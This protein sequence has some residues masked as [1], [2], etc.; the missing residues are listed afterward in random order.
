MQDLI[1]MRKI[2]ALT[3]DYKIRAGKCRGVKVPRLQPRR[4]LKVGG[5]ILVSQSDPGS[6]AKDCSITGED[7]EN[8]KT[9]EV[10]AELTASL[11]A[12]PEV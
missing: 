5:G 11:Y 4:H 1:F 10:E 6:R 8:V 2:T 3:R 12:L 7:T 9:E